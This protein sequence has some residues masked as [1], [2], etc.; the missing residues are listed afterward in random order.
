MEA[1]E[2]PAAATATTA[3]EITAPAVTGKTPS[4]APPQPTE[5]K[6]KEDENALTL[7]T[8][9]GSLQDVVDRVEA[10]KAGRLDTL[11]GYS[12]SEPGE[13]MDIASGSS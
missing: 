12:P 3:P 10:A 6:Q 2:A 11:E 13:S 1:G 5:E 8:T 4:A 7:E 9:K